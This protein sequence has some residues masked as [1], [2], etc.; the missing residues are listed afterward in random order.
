MFHFSPRQYLLLAVGFTLVLLSITLDR[1][2]AQWNAVFHDKTVAWHQLT[3]APGANTYVSSLDDSMLVLRSSSHSDARLTLFTRQNDGTTPDDLV[4]DLCNRDSCVY[5]PLDDERLNGAIADYTSG[6]PLRFVLMHPG[7][8]G[9]W[10]EY[11]GP[12]DG[13]STFDELID[14]IVTQLRKPAG[15]DAS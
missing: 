3:I 6:A 15:D 7:G 10:L 12:P 14:A 2:T 4:K 5:T 11:K 13:L 8:S 1:V 9:V